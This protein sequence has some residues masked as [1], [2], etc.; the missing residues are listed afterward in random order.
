MRH[1]LAGL[2]WCAAFV[3]LDAVQAVFLGGT[4]QRLDGF[5]TGLLVFGLSALVVGLW[6][7]RRSPEQ[8]GIALANRPA[9]IGLNISTAGGWVFYFGAVQLVEPAVAFTIF[10]GVIPLTAIAAGRFGIA[11]AEAARA[12]LERAGNAALAMGLLLLA[13]ITVFGWSGFV[14]GGPWIALAGAGLAALAG[15]FMTGMILYGQRLDR[16]GVGPGALFALRFPLYLVLA[17]VGWQFGLDTKAPVPPADLALA[18]AAGFLVLAFPV[19]AVQKAISLSSSL[20]VGAAAALIPFAVFLMQAF[21]G[22]V[23][24][25]NATL[26]G[27]AVCF[28]GAVLASIGRGR[29][30]AGQGVG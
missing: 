2:A 20:T 1:G 23:D 29:G 14:R 6:C 12:P 7:W 22:R 4:L 8:I 28:M 16:T 27:L 30:A 26:A 24:H 21:E 11:E 3:A 13:A 10:T 5:L 9:L 19:Y 17:L 18:V 15:V 25:S